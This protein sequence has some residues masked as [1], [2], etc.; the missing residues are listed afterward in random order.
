M[1]SA[2]LVYSFPAP[3]GRRGTA[4]VAVIGLHVVLVAGLVLGLAVHWPD[5]PV[6]LPRPITYTRATPERT[7]PLQ[8]PDGARDWHFRVAQPVE[9][10]PIVTIEPPAPTGP[11]ERAEP[12]PVGHGAAADTSVL[13]RSARKLSG[14]EPLYPAAARR[15]GE[16][17]AV[18]VRVRVG[19][20][21][22]AHDV[23]IAGSSGSPR[24]DEAAVAAVRRWRF[25]PAA[26]AGGPIESWTTLRV[27]F[28]LTE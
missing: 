15:L 25:E 22:R 14:E 2:I 26:T 7:P 17:G 24:L 11:V 21:G 3:L 23:E 27:R 9:P 13:L 1:P 12:A 19:A 16:Q 4:A 18:L 8:V 6:T 10:P 5:V 20:D 28:R